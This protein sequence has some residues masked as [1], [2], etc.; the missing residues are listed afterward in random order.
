MLIDIKNCGEC[1]AYCGM[2][3]E[4][5]GSRIVT[6]Y[7]SNNPPP[8]CPLRKREIAVEDAFRL[9][10]CRDTTKE[11]TKGCVE[12]DHSGRDHEST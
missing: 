10:F 5:G 6:T 2:G 3:C 8:W 7:P 1:P 12:P 11:H 4:V 9:V